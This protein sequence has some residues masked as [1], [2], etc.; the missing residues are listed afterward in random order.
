MARQDASELIF[1]PDFETPNFV[2]ESVT[3]A[4]DD[5]V[6]GA[7]SANIEAQALIPPPVVALIPFPQFHQLMS[8]RFLHRPM[9]QRPRLGVTCSIDISSAARR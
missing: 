2:V 8:I 1:P 4:S 6:S 9:R 3:S 7:P 5:K